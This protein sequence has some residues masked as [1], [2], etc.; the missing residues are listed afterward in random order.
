MV[1]R[2]VSVIFGSLAVGFTLLLLFLRPTL[3]FNYDFEN[4]FAEDDPE[5]VFYNEFRSLFENDNDYLLVALGNEP[6]IFDKI[7]LDKASRVEENLRKLENVSTVQSLLSAEEPVI[8]SFGVRREKILEWDTAESLSKSKK[9]VEADTPLLGNLVSED[10]KH[11]LVVLKN[12]QLIDKYSGDTL[13]YE[14]VDVLRDS[15]ITDFQIAGKIKAQAEFVSL[16]Q[17]EFSFFLGFSLVLI[18]VWLYLIFRSLWGI[19]IPVLV[20]GIGFFWSVAFLLLTGGELDV[21]VV[22]QPPILLVIGLSGIVHF[23]SSYQNRL[24]EGTPKDSAIKQT[25]GELAIPVFLTCLTTAVG[26]FSLTVTDVVS[27]NRFGWFTGFGVLWMFFAIVLILPIAL[28]LIP[29]L[30]SKRQGNASRLWQRVLGFWFIGILR[31]RWIVH[32]GFVVLSI[33]AAVGI[34]NIK[35]NGYILDNLPTDHPLIQ[36]FKFFDRNFGGS[37]PL[38]FHVGVGEESESLLEYKV[39][40]ELNKVEVF[41]QETFQT[42][43]LLSPL[44]LIKSLNKAQN[45]GNPKAFGFPTEGQFDRMTPFMDRFAENQ[46]IPLLTT[47]RKQ[48][49]ISTY[50]ADV[51]S[52]RG[53]ELEKQLDDYLATHISPELIHVKMTGTSFLI[54]RSHRQVTAQLAAGLGVAFL[55]VAL[56]TGILFRSWRMALIGLIPNLVPLLWMGAMMYL[57]GVNLNLSTAIIF[58]VAFGIAVD[59]SIHFITKLGAERKKGK[60]LIYGLKRTYLT[61][62]KALVLTTIILSSGFLVLTGSDFQ[63]TFYAGL[64]IGVSLIFAL[65]ADLLW[66]PVL[67]LP[68][69][70]MWKRNQ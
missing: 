69:S 53:E 36:E 11:L 14:V 29:P 45:Q 50:M 61:T 51:G 59:D 68:L 34:S 26:F 15:G 48:G 57:F 18:L 33:S 22:M 2:R 38:E 52:L 4:F 7:F 21:L 60:S 9:R 1:T 3:L 31:R 66:L 6:D 35:T 58:A 64:L 43:T 8:S 19:L 42:G 37:K 41:I 46:P 10:F 25:F 24:Q 30:I 17:E 47:D 32:I 65:L 63:I 55:C 5:L 62:G 54:D 12:E 39:L 16:L 23:M 56:L 49:R 28:Y 13:Y 20:L 70:K 27:L 44:T 67:I 40:Q